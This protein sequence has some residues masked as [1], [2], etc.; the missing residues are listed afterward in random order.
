MPNIAIPTSTHL[1]LA[2]TNLN[3]PNPDNTI[4]EQGNTTKTFQKFSKSRTP[5]M[6]NKQ[7]H[8]EPESEPPYLF[9][10]QN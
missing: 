3:S 7:N 9:S 2:E 4:D 6:V 1:K 10:K 8:H 5:F